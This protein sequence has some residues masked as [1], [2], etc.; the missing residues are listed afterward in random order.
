M[1]ETQLSKLEILDCTIRDGGYINNWDFPE[2]MVLDIYRNLSKAGVDFVEVGF[3]DSNDDSPLWRKC[4]ENLL[5]EIKGCKHGAKLAVMVD[6][7]EIDINQFI[8]ASESM[9]DLVRVAV[10]KN[11]IPQALE[12]IKAIKDKGY[13]TSLQLMGY[14]QYNK[15]ECRELFR[16]LIEF[17]ADYVYVADSYGS[18][19][20]DQVKNLIEPLVS[21]GL[22]KV[23]FHPHNNLQMAFA[24]T[25]EAFKA[26][27]HIID[28]TLYGIG[29]GAGNL[30]TE[31]LLAYMEAENRNKYNVNHAL[32]S[33]DMWLLPLKKEYEWGYQ[34]PYMLSGTCKCHPSY[35]KELIEARRYTIEDVWKALREIKE[36][37]PVGFDRSLLRDIMDNS[38]FEYNLPEKLPDVQSAKETT[39][40]FD[41]SAYLNRHS[42]RTFLVLA[43]GPSLI[44]YTKEITEFVEKFDPIILGS[45]YLKGIIIPHYHA[46]VNKKRFIQYVNTVS[47]QSKLLLSVYFND[48]FVVEYTD[49]EYEKIIY[50]NGDRNQ[51][52]IEN[53]IVS[54]DCSSVSM[55]LIAVAIVMG[56]DEVYVAGMDGYVSSDGKKSS[57]FYDE[58]N[59]TKSLE[60]NKLRQQWGERTL[61]VLNNYLIGTGRSGVNIITSTSYERYYRGIESLI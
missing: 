6:F 24:N 16:L 28:S 20:P 60:F 21:L 38:K 55:L 32:N 49:R 17:C 11:K 9:I 33:V 18:L 57:Y 1:S 3:R 41:V 34:L 30:P 22:F 25:L 29:R 59:E 45:N 7:G 23:G 56:G 50:R 36:H 27:I 5:K 44:E 54:N 51:L 58:K 48:E 14:P 47:T 39:G 42:D 26:G 19:M 35:A 52:T 4:P 61:E 15:K 13:L 8:S 37:N 31:A 2:Q 10:H 53:G 12:F 40:L 46:F 43:N